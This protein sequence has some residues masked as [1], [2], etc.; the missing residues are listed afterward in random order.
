M[1]AAARAEQLAQSGEKQ[2]PAE[3][4]SEV[5]KPMREVM[6]AMQQMASAG[7]QANIQ[8][9]LSHSSVTQ[10]MTPDALLACGK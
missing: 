7:A 8:K 9:H 1:L 10:S 2:V 4:L 3:W 6:S 5:S